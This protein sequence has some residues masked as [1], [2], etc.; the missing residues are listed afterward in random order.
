MWA[1]ALSFG[2][3]IFSAIGKFFDWRENKAHERL[4][5]Q[6]EQLRTMKGNVDASDEMRRIE[7][8]TSRLDDDARGNALRRYVRHRNNSDK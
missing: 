4:G 1:A 8:E 3:R 6:D 7:N 2:A 5:R